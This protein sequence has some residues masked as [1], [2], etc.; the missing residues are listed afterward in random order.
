MAQ[1]SSSEG[2]KASA[3]AVSQAK[4]GRPSTDYTTCG[5]KEDNTPPKQACSDKVW[6]VGRCGSQ[7]LLSTQEMMNNSPRDDREAELLALRAGK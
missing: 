2:V 4:Q 1:V 5:A 6:Q 3:C 7:T